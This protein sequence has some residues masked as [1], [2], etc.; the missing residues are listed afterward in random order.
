MEVRDST[1]RPKAAKTVATSRMYCISL[2]Q[3]NFVIM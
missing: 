2:F 3:P 1:E